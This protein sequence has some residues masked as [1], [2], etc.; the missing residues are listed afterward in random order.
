V[1]QRTREIYEANAEQWAGVRKPNQTELAMALANRSVSPSI[2]LGCGPGWHARLFSPPVVALDAAYAMLRLVRANAPNALPVQADLEALP[3]RRGALNT[4]W[5]RNSYVHLPRTRVPAAL[6]DLHR[7]LRPD[8]RAMVLLF[9]GDDEGRDMFKDHNDFPDRYFSRWDL[10]HLRDVVVGAGFETDDCE[11]HAERE[12]E[13]HLELTRARTLPDLIGPDMRLLVCGLNPS[14]YAA[15]AGIEF[16]RPGNRFWPAAL[17]AG[18]ASRDRDPWHAFRHHG[19]GFTDL[20]KRASVGASELT[21]D[22]YRAGHSRVDRLVRWLQ[23]GA[24][25]FVGLAG[26]RAAVDRR[27]QPGLQP[28]GIGGRPAYVMPSTSGLNARMPLRDLAEHLRA[29]AAVAA[30]GG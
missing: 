26:W 23:P 13:V 11:I 29:A 1:D 20:V 24:V 30:S 22:E 28:E 16:A 18:I 17:A 4:A 3:F 19:I 2:D 27:A 6:A 5:A 7:I 8:A 25:V 9:V 15:D 21:T 12:H 10:D 14:L